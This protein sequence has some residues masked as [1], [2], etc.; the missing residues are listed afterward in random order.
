M[1][2]DVWNNFECPVCHTELSAVDL[3]PLRAVIRATRV[4]SVGITDNDGIWKLSCGHVVDVIIDRT[5][6]HDRFN[7]QLKARRAP[8]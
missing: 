7:F 1:T 4:G 6:S 2:T 5:R 3:G 8:A